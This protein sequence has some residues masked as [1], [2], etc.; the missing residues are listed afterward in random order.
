MSIAYSTRSGSRAPAPM[1]VDL[2]ASTPKPPLIVEL[3]PRP[4]IVIDAPPL[5][6][7]SR[8]RGALGLEA[9]GLSGGRGM[10][11]RLVVA[12]DG[13]WLN[14]DN[15]LK[16]G[17]LSIPSNVTRISRAIK[18][19]SQDGIPQIVNY[20]F[21]VGS[22][23]GPLNRIISGT[24]GE[25]LGDN[26]REAYSFIA[27]NYHP[28]DEIFLLG[29]SRGAFTAR[30]IAGLIGEVGL[31]TKKGLHALPEVFEDVQQRRN[32]RY[33]PKNP[34]VPFP[35]KPSADSPRYKHELERRGLTR[36]DIPIKAIGVWDTVGS[37][38]AP[39]VGFLTKLG[40]QSSESK[41]MTFYD[42]KL[43]ACIEN[44]FQALALDERRG[45]FSPAVWEKPE[46]NKTI[47]RQ[48][49]FP[50]VHSNVGG[51]YD[52]QQLANITLA[53]MMSQLEPFLDMREEYLFEQDEDN[54]RYYRK[55][56]E[57]LRPWSFGEITNSNTG[58][59]AIGGRTDR[60]P[61]HYHA[62]DPLTGRTTPRPLR[63]TNEYIHPS[64]RTRIRLSG[65]GVSDKGPYDCPALTTAYK[66]VVDYGPQAT[67]SNTTSADPDIFWK[68]KSK[69]G[70]GVRT[71]REAPLW[72]LE[73]EL[74]RKD[75]KAYAYVKR[76]PATG[77]AS[78]SA[79]SG[80]GAAKR[81]RSARPVSASA[82]FDA[83]AP[84]A[85]GVGSR[86]IS[87]DAERLGAGTGVGRRSFVDPRREPGRRSAGR[88]SAGGA[89]ARDLEA[90]RSVREV[91]RRVPSRSRSRSRPRSVG[92]RDE[93]E[94]EDDEDE[95]D[96]EDRGD[97]ETEIREG[98]PHRRRKDKAWWEGRGG[99]G[100]ERGGE[101]ERERGGERERERERGGGGRSPRR[102]SM[103]V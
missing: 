7:R 40:L 21:G 71:L 30:S 22:Q 33:V 46:G 55:Q 103:R 27:N 43:S 73:R 47:L 15:G 16:N 19:V 12:C 6:A 9:P 34:N 57:D 74:C 85:R 3:P 42:T 82:H 38:G 53:W 59:Y 26:V 45:A 80:G 56:R 81:R 37:L 69:D 93:V 32:P 23:G 31:L 88:A 89:T 54:D 100:F 68:L 1:F 96:S 76:P 48:V 87:A 65:P 60:T 62:V 77:S 63:Q 78:A 99:D 13:T 52:D 17:Q 2:P 35:N 102:S 66:L 84:P 36:L 75:P 5:R 83:G 51:G 98:M 97:G 41:E 25:G 18:A 50:G 49:W 29:F 14:S 4:P 70:D 58:L 72:R 101:R 67:P 24:T 90:R 20:H 64:V 8:S 91:P 94:E 86:R 95:Y 11:K 92:F 28:G 44:A 39:R 10:F 61:G 79:G